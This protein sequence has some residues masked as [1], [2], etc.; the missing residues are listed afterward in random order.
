[1]AKTQS[2]MLAL[3]TAAPEFSLPDP[4]GK[5]HRLGD[6][7]GARALVVAFICNH[8][9]YVKHMI[10]GLVQFARDYSG[11]GLSVVAINPNDA[12]RYP[13]DSPPK[14]AQLAAQTA[15]SP[16]IVAS[17]VA[18]KAAASSCRTCS[19]A[20][21]PSRRSASVKPFSESPGS[22]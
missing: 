14:M 4:A 20:I 22:P 21:V 6:F 7:A 17:P 18:A 1:M 5:L 16:V 13:D 9:P 3:G 19:Q 8:C 15:S 2:R 11:Q 10:D 12:S